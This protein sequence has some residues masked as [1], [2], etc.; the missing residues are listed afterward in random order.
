MFGQKDASKYWRL[1]HANAIS[2]NVSS[3]THPQ[4]DISKEVSKGHEVAAERIPASDSL[5]QE[6]MSNRCNCGEISKTWA[7]VLRFRDKVCNT[8]HLQID[9]KMSTSLARLYNPRGYWKSNQTKTTHLPKGGAHLTEIRRTRHFRIWR[10]CRLSWWTIISWMPLPKD[11]SLMCKVF[12]PG[13]SVSAWKNPSGSCPLPKV[14]DSSF[15]E[16]Q[17]NKWAWCINAHVRTKMP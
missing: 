15:L 14:K 4:N 8:G 12:N 2:R 11:E 6:E 7:M 10:S 3:L 16:Y 9:V 13:Q 1:G 5:W 17:Q